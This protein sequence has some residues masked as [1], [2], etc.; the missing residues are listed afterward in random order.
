MSFSSA[1]DFTGE[2]KDGEIAV[3]VAIIGAGP[4]GLTSAY[5][6]TKAG[7]TVAIVEKDP[8]Y[9]GGISRTVEHEG[10]RFDIGGHRFFSKSQQ[11]V[12]L[13][14]EILPDDFIQ[15]PRMSR[16]YYEGKFYSYPLR[17]FEALWNLGIWRSTLCMASFAK[18]Q[19]FPRRTVKSFEDWTTNQFGWKLYSIFFKTYTE[20][21][22]GMPCDEMSADWA[23]Q[24]I[25]GLSLWGAV[26]DGLRR[27]LGLNKRPN[28]GQAVKTL[29]E[30]FRYPRLGPGMMWEAAR[31]R[32]VESG[33]GE[34]LMGHALR[35]LASDGQ[36][37]WR[38][39][40]DS[41]EGD[42]TIRAA[43]AI[44]SAPMRELAAR[45]HP[46]PQTTLQASELKY[47][48]FLTVALKIR[49]DDLFPDNW[50]YIHDSKVK[51]GRIQNFRSWSPE[52]VPD[53]EMACVGLEYFCFEGDGLWSMADDDLVALATREMVTL[54]L[55]RA[56][57][58]TGGFV[59][60]Q[61]KAYPVYDEDYAANVAAMREELEARHPSLH[62]V[63][64]NGMHRY[65]NQD[66]AMMTAMLTVENI[67]AG[68]RI[69]DTWCVNEDAEYHE[70]GDEGET[71]ALPAAPGSRAPTPDQA[72]ALASVREVPAR[73]AG[74]SEGGSKREAA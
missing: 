23:A 11:V 10:Y 61:E 44:S 7:L 73:I 9:V 45:L 57:E 60:R 65:N 24:R 20:K 4:A 21:V 14:N 19:L 5:L 52:M 33:K 51:V 3:D 26:T 42:V 54:G 36:G 28:D 48:D 22:W 2:A 15:R 27:S 6:L 63:G 29:L 8:H 25:K 66:H 56:D 70:A 40:A 69:Y 43:H 50:I 49:A 38:L 62:L 55:C 68:E 59:V 71:K 17:A 74:S 64:R 34:V 13:W 37:G 58:V 46:L 53:D 16:I 39:T 1:A 12:D 35:Q 47:R 72:A 67:L 41:G 32:I 18:A 30:T 31:D